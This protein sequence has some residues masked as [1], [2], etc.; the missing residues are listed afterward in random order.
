MIKAGLGKL[1]LPELA[2]RYVFDRLSRQGILSL[3]L[4]QA[5]AFKVYDL[6]PH[7][8]D[9][10]DRLIIAQAVIENMTVLTAD[11]AFAKYPVDV[12]WCGA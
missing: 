6:P 12:V 8:R 4:T 10:F 5:H 7:H 1:K 9:P 3:P 11:R 2:P